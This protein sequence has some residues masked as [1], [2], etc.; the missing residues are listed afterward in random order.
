MNFFKNFFTGASS[1]L[2]VA[3][4]GVILSALALRYPVLTAWLGES[5]Q[6]DILAFASEIKDWG[7]GFV[8]LFVKQY[9]ATG[10]TNAATDEAE[11]RI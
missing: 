1:H 5:I 7:W 6:K 2:R 3:I 11:K 8:M 4:L 10:G 9:N